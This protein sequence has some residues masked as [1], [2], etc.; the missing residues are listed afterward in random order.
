MIDGR[1]EVKRAFISGTTRR[2]QMQIVATDTGVGFRPDTLVLSLYDVTPATNGS[3][4]WAWTFCPFLYRCWRYAYPAVSVTSA[5]VNS[6]NDADVSAFVDVAGNVDFNLEPAD[7]EFETP[8]VN[9]AQPHQRVLLFTWT[10]DGS[11]GKV[12]KHEIVLN[13]VPDRETVAT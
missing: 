9:I 5:I 12:A 11:P 1:T 7:T 13:L 2:V 10:W 3:G 6:Q 4:T 8:T